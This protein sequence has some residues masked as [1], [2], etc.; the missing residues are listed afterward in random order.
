MFNKI[1]RKA[2]LIINSTDNTN[3]K[4]Y[5]KSPSSHNLDKK[6]VP[7]VNFIIFFF[8]VETLCII[9]PHF[10]IEPATSVDSYA[11]ILYPL[12]YHLLFLKK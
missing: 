8:H 1:I 3:V 4:E 5:V 6:I 11:D 7:K 10:I 12:E 9:P 2:N